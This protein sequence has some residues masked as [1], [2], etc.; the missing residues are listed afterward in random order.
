MI[1]GITPQILIIA[2]NITIL[3]L[4]SNHNARRRGRRGRSLPGRRAVITVSCICWLF[5]VSIAPLNIIAILDGA[6]F[7]IPVWARHI[8]NKLVNL[9]VAG[10]PIIYTAIHSGF[11]KCIKKLLGCD[12]RHPTFNGA[13]KCK[14]TPVI[15]HVVNRND[16]SGQ[17]KNIC[18]VT[19]T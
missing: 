6:K 12:V 5:L 7:D 3:C 17:S 4:V 8:A 18:T 19:A 10:N 11:R 13:T 2:C 9:N 15:Q 14:N 16:S 1:F